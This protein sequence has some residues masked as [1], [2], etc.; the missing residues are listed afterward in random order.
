MRLKG[1]KECITYSKVMDR[2]YWA[3][4]NLWNSNWDIWCKQDI[5]TC[6]A[7]NSNYLIHNIYDEINR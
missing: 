2:I 3:E 6:S 7:V 1:N 4:K 5:D